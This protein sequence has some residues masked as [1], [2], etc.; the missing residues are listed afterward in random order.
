VT[1]DWDRIEADWA[2]LKASAKRQWEK[3]SDD[4]LDS[5]A[6][7]RERLSASVQATYGIT[8]ET[9]ERQVSFWQS[10]QRSQQA[11]GVEE[12]VREPSGP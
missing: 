5:I 8:K 1:V 9:T 4:Q 7:K 10:I 2:Q 6:G 12:P 3:L 11:G